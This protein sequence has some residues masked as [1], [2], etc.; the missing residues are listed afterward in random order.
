MTLQQASALMG[1]LA[2][3]NIPGDAQMR[4]NAGG[5]QTWDVSVPAGTILMGDQVARLASYCDANTLSLSFQFSS[6]TVT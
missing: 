1:A 4:F 5:A 3:Q 6:L 2:S